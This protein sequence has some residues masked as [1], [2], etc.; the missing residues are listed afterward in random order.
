MSSHQN[1]YA[2]SE[3]KKYLEKAVFHAYG[4]EEPKTLSILQ[5][6]FGVVISLD[7]DAPMAKFDS[8]EQLPV[9]EEDDFNKHDWKEEIKNMD[10]VYR[11]NLAISPFNWVT[12]IKTKKKKKWV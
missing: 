4:V 1:S 7:I 12:D 9:G 11:F 8:F 6:L 2:N 10:E 5:E 3:K